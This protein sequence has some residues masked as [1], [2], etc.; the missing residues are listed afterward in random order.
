[1]FLKVAARTSGVTIWIS[2]RM[3]S[4]NSSS[5]RGLFMQARPFR[6]PHRK[7]SAPRIFTHDWVKRERRQ[8]GCATVSFRLYYLIFSCCQLPLCEL[9]KHTTTFCI[10]LL[11]FL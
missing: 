7:N 2:C 10:V 1:M 3:F 6:W 11:F 4:R 5:V 8:A 9:P